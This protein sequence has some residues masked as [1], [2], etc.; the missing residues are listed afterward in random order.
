MEKY[1]TTIILAL[2]TFFGVRAQHGY[3]TGMCGRDCEWQYDGYTLT[4]SATGDKTNVRMDNYNTKSNPAPWKKKNLN[5]RKVRIE[6]GI[7]RIGD[8]AFNNL[9]N[10]KEAIFADNSLKEIG[11]GAFMD[12]RQ[13]RNVKFPGSLE[14]IG[15]IAF[16]NCD[17][18]TTVIIPDDCR[19]GEQAFASCDNLKSIDLSPTC[20]L[21]KNVFAGEASVNGETRH[22]LFTGEVVQAPAYITPENCNKFGLARFTVTPADEDK[23]QKKEYGICIS[24]LDTQIPE[25]LYIRNNTYALVIGNQ[26]YRFAGNVP[27]ALH[28]ANIFAKY[29]N[30][31]L[32]IP[33]ENIHLVENATKEMIM[34]DELKD[35]LGKLP[36][37]NLKTLIV[38]YSGNG[39]P[40]GNDS[41]KAYLLPTE[42]RASTPERGIA[43]NDFYSRLGDLGFNQ[44][45]VFIDASFSGLNRDGEGI[46]D[47]SKTTGVDAEKIIPRSGNMVVF[48]ASS[49]SEAA[50]GYH[51]EGHGLLT[52]WILKEM[53]D[54]NGIMSLGTLSDRLTTNVAKTAPLIKKNRTQNPTIV[55]SD[56]LAP[57]WRSIRL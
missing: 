25:A 55:A 24:E 47:A 44:T 2:A 27:N 43:L 48:S 39:M 41:N 7:S 40:D 35:W 6:K 4:V 20:I 28:D 12:C 34:T 23:H 31:T 17:A 8:C 37:R 9:T 11:W 18:M 29:C 50:L 13:L 49:G 42:V 33:S 10:L 54:T 51:K 53:H 46:T 52:Y 38:Y 19:V 26:D 21:G 32:G 36:D 14:E 56:K 57:K 30:K 15:K 3:E 16:A 22:T 5:I 45:T 1:I